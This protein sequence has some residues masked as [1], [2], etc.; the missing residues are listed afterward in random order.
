[1]HGKALKS[2]TGASANQVSLSVCIRG[3]R[4]EGGL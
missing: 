1:M 2:I 4:V 3:C